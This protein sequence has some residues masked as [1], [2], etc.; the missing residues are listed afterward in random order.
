MMEGTYR[1]ARRTCS[2]RLRYAASFGG[3]PEGGDGEGECDD[4]D[5]MAMTAEGGFGFGML[6]LSRGKSVSGRISRREMWNQTIQLEFPKE[7]TS[8]P[9]K[10]NVSWPKKNPQSKSR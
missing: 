4:F 8:S 6:T 2:L 3:E 9:R 1:C 10:L 5:F 7:P